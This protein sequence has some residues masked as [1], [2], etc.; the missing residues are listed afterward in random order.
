M[1]AQ[2]GLGGVTFLV[3]DD[4]GHEPLVARPV[5][6]DDHR[7]LSRCGVVGEDGFD[8]AEFDAVAAEFDLV[9]DASDEF[10]VSVGAASGEVAAAVHAA[11]GGAVGVGDEAGGGEV[12]SVEVAAGEEVAGDVELSGDAG[13]DGLEVGVEDVDL[14]VP[15]GVADG[16]GAGGGHLAGF[17]AELGAADGGFGGAVFVDD[18]DARVLGAPFV[19]GLAEECFAAED[20][21]LGGGDVGG[22]VFEERQV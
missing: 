16:D 6:A 12:G 14:G 21:L 8:F 17:D 3:G 10:E 5:L 19:Q 9:V 2:S 1:F 7:S 20:E 13:G 22:K 4:V 11:A 15:D 18:G